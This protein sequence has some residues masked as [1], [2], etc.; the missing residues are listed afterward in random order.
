V[1][2]KALESLK[3]WKAKSDR[4][5]LVI[6]G[7]R[8]VGKTWLM[9]EFGRTEYK[10]CAYINFDSNARML[11]LFSNDMDIDRILTGL[12]M[13]SACDIEAHDTL[14]I[15]DE[16]QE[17]AAALTSLK[18]FCENAPEYHII[19]AGS[20]LGVALHAGASFPV[21]KI[22]FMDLYP[23][24][25]TEFLLAS[26][27][28]ELAGLI[29]AHDVALIK[30]F[31]D[32]FVELLKTYY[33]TGGMPEVLAA[34]TLKKDYAKVREIQ[35]RILETYELDFSKHAPSEIVPRLRMLWNSIPS[36]LVRENRK[37]VYGLVREGARAK[38]YESALAWLCDCG[39]AY[40]IVRVSKPAIPLQAYEDL[41]AFKLFV[42]DIGLLGAMSGLDSR[43][44]LEG[45]AV[46]QEFKGALT[47]QFVLQ[48]LKTMKELRIFYWSAEKSEAEVDFILQ[49]GRYIVPLEVKAEENLR[50]K[51][52]KSY[53]ERYSPPLSIRTSMSD[54]RREDWLLNLP[55]YMINAL[56]AFIPM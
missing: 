19:A 32:T 40:R 43:T 15:F 56:P 20:L 50:A 48:Q 24:D 49:S 41:H 4:K 26:G 18:Y 42:F 5:P 45:N 29:S 17:C 27:K 2:R 55:L 3:A 33:F 34:F 25:F 54:Y 1:T 11:R 7:A 23:L 39:L 36:Q 35:R 8:Q 51:S 14:V 22:E 6:R 47:E 21:G 16:I 44:L 38:E 10:N 31:S 12:R 28:S 52:L 13:E 37:F 46:F 9:K 30:T 53:R